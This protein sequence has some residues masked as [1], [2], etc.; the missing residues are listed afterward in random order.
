MKI[1]TKILAMNLAMA[2]LPVAL[3]GILALYQLQQ[4]SEESVANASETLERQAVELLQ[5]GVREEIYLLNMLKDRVV[6]DVDRLAQS[7]TIN[8]YVTALNGRNDVWNFLA[9]KEARGILDGLL[10]MCYVK[11][12]AVEQRL[13]A[14]MMVLE[15]LASARGPVKL[16]SSKMRDWQATNQYTQLATKVT[17]PELKIGGTVVASSASFGDPAPMVDDVTK[18]FGGTC[19]IF[20][21]INSKGDMLRVSTTVPTEAG[22]RAVGTYIPA[23]MPDDSTNP[24]IKAV[25]FDQ[26][27]YQGRA[28]VV[29]AWY[30]TKYIPLKD[31][32]GE[33]IGMF[34][35]GVREQESDAIAHAIQ[36]TEVGKRG[37]PYVLD[38]QGYIILHPRAD[39]VGKHVVRD[40]HVQELKEVLTNRAV[41]VTQKIEYSFENARKFVF[42]TFFKEWDWI[43]CVS[44]YWDDL[45]RSAI[46]KTRKNAEDEMLRMHAASNVEVGGEPKPLYNQVRYIDNAGMEIV[47]VQ[48]GDQGSER[49]RDLRDKGGMDWFKAFSQIQRGYTVFDYPAPAE[50][51]NTAQFELR[52]AS[53]VFVGS[54]RAGMI[55]VSLDWEVIRAM[56]RQHV[57]GKTGYSYIVNSEGKVLAHPKYQISDGVFITDERRGKE[58]AE[59]AKSRMLTGES[60]IGMYDFEGIRK[61]VAF[62]PFQIGKN[63]YTLAVA[64]PVDEFLAVPN[65]L[66]RRAAEKSTQIT[67]TI[68]LAVLCVGALGTVVALY[69]ARTFKRTVARAIGMASCIADGDLPNLVES[70]GSDEIGDLDRAFNRMIEST[71]AT[72]QQAQSIAMGSYD[73]VIQPRSD[74]DELGYALVGMTYALKEFK[75]SG[76]KQDWLKTGLSRLGEKLRG[77]QEIIPLANN[78]L[79]FLAEYLKIQVGVIYVSDED[80]TFHLVASYAYTRRKGF[81]NTFKAGEGIVGQ[82][83]LERK[84]FILDNLPDDYMTVSSGT[85]EAIPHNVVVLPLI[86]ENDVLGVLEMGSLEPIGD[87]AKDLLEH[88]AESIAIALHSAAS[89]TRL[90][91]LL[92]QTQQQARELKDQQEELRQTNEELQQQQQTLQETNRQLEDR[93]RLLEKQKEQIDFKNR[94][95]ARAQQD[96]ERKAQ[97][98]DRASKY[99]SEFLANMS[100]E[101]RTPLNSLLILSRLLSE[102]KDGNLSEKQVGFAQT[103][104][105]AGTDLLALINDILDL[106]KVEA[107]RMEFH[108]E[109]VSI[110]E[111]CNSMEET[112]RHVAAEKNLAFVI[113][114]DPPLPKVIRA[115]R[116]RIEQILK[117]L[118]SNAFKFTQQGRVEVRIFTP[119]RNGT[120]EVAFAVNDTGIG[121]PADKIGLIF[122]AFQQADGTTSRKYGGTG[123]GLSISRKLAQSMGGD[124]T[125]ESVEGKGSTFTL[126]LP[127]AAT[128]TPAKA[129]PALTAP[130]TTPPPAVSNAGAVSVSESLS[131]DNQPAALAPVAQ[132]ASAED[133]EALDR[134]YAR[135]I[136][137]DADNAK[138]G[139]RILLVIEDDPKFAKILIDLAHERGFKCLA[140]N[141]GPKGLQLA[142]RYQPNGII[143]D[144][145]LPGMNGWAVMQHL[146]DSARTRH[147]PV[148]FI[149]ALDEQNQAMQMGAV[150]FLTKPV[151]LDQIE[152]ALGRIERVHD[153]KIKK[154][155]IVEDNATEAASIVELIDVKEVEKTVARTGK[156]A[157]ELLTTQGFDTVILDLGLSDMSGFEVLD[158]LQR[159]GKAPNMPIIIHTGRD[160]SR[161]E[162]TRL[163]KYSD[164][165]I[166]KGARSAERLLDEAILF[167]HLVESKL[168]DKQQKMVRHAHETEMVLKNKKILIVDDDMRN[169]YSLTNVLEG[170]SV[171]TLAA[172]NGK[173]A[174]GMLE[175]NP[176]VDLVLMDIMMPEMDGYE[177][178]KRIRKIPQFRRLPIIALTAKAMKGDREKCI[179]AGASDYL[180]K[181]VDVDKLISVLRVFLY[182]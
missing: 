113:T 28:F 66:Q 116:Q 153:R 54:E 19:T 1:S 130:A 70:V 3:M 101:L 65:A 11:R 98:L 93:T 52:V 135:D 161:E 14:S 71:R 22:L 33:V 115:D 181:P 68:A 46:D 15:R 41:G 141:N 10:R 109:D 173:Q 120:A 84:T 64:T 171:Q 144:I 110:E 159:S 102:N 78:L 59:L 35:V 165:I 39:L 25:V 108:F 170:L 9:E 82:A 151:S 100:H 77:E 179:E 57:Y 47:K 124:V 95:L 125:L 178:T 162:E 154:L 107:G 73:I 177:A 123:L 27:P 18:I 34:Y 6:R 80:G 53:P 105:K 169:V 12:E 40:L 45:Y 38:S 89:R 104:H 60:G 166:I 156:E 128:A 164:S 75:E 86:W 147:I 50:A 8:E 63:Q 81:R 87:Q 112:F 44:G 62:A 69:F 90:N 131:Q 182:R 155:L 16:D 119:N 72:V 136:K 167:L 133:T 23:I 67:S 79:C 51:A 2:L 85:G 55:V 83:A 152:G 37:Y 94:E 96:L 103:I 31:D 24:V 17:L 172:Q 36:T 174:L 160:L 139:E 48:R 175:Q 132:A 20:Q 134:E 180:T 21:R 106:S 88:A 56:L 127:V 30:I 7:P 26:K 5:K 148:H 143:L 74:H 61:Y 117:N 140:T 92:R 158:H 32:S 13:H 146:K 122:Q 49:R 138:P 91:E 149:S 99:K 4:F 126:Y 121:I 114:Q 163:R 29:N 111:I 42:Y 43:V 176:D 76:E 129:A 150:G 97:D 118:L 137:D 58:L 157:L 142:D 168:P 145:M